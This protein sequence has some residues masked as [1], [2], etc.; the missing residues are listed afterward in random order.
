MDATERLTY[1]R[2]NVDDDAFILALLTSPG[3]LKFIGD[4]GVS[5][6]A[7]ARR[8][9]K[10]KIFP[11]YRQPGGGPFLAIRKTD[12]VV[13]GNVGTYQR[14]GLNRPDFGFAFLPEY[15]SQGFAHE[16]SLAGLDYAKK[17]GHQ[18]VLAITL[19]DNA[20]SL[21]LLT[22]LGFQRQ[23][24]LVTLPGDDAELVLLRKTL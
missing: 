13:L 4:R 19:P 21:K 17:Y 23:P 7:S 6:L 12:G 15:H 14:P 24:D 10:E 2:V 22:K 18:E 3:W 1:R 20:P 9:I 16:A 5:D 11:A 8:Y